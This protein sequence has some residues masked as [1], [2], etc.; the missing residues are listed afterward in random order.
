MKSPCARANA[1][2]VQ[3]AAVSSPR[4]RATWQVASANTGSGRRGRPALGLGLRAPLLVRLGPLLL[5]ATTSDMAFW[6]VTPVSL[7]SAL[8]LAEDPQ[9]V[10]LGAHA[11]R[12]S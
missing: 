9:V 6:T 5:L 4:A 3:T 11:G 12:R 1:P 7:D 2:R 8:G 10:E